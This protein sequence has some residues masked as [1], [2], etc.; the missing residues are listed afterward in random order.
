MDIFFF[1]EKPFLVI[2]LVVKVHCEMNTTSKNKE[3][4]MVYAQ[5]A[6]VLGRIVL[7]S[8]CMVTQ[9]YLGLHITF[10]IRLF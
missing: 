3:N 7:F 5:F 2:F 6:V 1:S 4:E 8:D 10:T 9:A